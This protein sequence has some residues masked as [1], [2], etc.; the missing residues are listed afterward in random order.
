MGYTVSQGKMFYPVG[1]RSFR[2]GQPVP[3]NIIDM[4]QEL[5]NLSGLMAAGVLVKNSEANPHAVKM[6]QDKR[7]PG[8]PKFAQ[9]DDSVAAEKLLAGFEDE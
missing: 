8:R 4:M 1:C 2:G 6:E 5:G 3:Q 9:V 7:G